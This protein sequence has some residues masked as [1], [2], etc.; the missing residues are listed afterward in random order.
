MDGSKSNFLFKFNC[1]FNTSRN[2]IIDPIY[3]T[4]EGVVTPSY[5]LSNKT[6]PCGGFSLIA[7]IIG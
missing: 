4:K 6:V 3:K 1:L 2:N 7:T 5:F